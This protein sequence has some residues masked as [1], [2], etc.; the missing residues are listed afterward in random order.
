MCVYMNMCLCLYLIYTFKVALCTQ[1]HTFGTFWPVQATY[2]V[3]NFTTLP[4]YSGTWQHNV[5]NFVDMYRKFQRYPVEIPI[6]FMSVCPSQM[7]RWI[8]DCLVTAA[9]YRRSIFDVT[10]LKV[11]HT[12]LGLTANVARSTATSVGR[13]SSVGVA[14]RYLLDGPGIATLWRTYLSHPLLTIV[15]LTQY[16]L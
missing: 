13:C 16:S 4:Y 8:G 5:T 3:Q 12:P 11:Q 10:Q 7:S 9:W 15:G 6:D 1:L 14:N 2:M